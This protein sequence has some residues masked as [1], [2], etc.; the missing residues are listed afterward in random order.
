MV[1]K[2]VMVEVVNTVG[3]MGEEEMEEVG[4]R[5]FEEDQE[6]VE[7]W[8]LSIRYPLICPPPSPPPPVDLPTTSPPP[9]F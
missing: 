2:M 8:V 3:V 4:R 7:R 1:L 6:Q 5:E 9:G